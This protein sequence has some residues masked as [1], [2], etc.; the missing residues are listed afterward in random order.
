MAV[1]PADPKGIEMNDEHLLNT[2]QA[3]ELLA[4]HERTLIQDRSS[5]RL[6]IPFIRLGRAIRYQ[7]TDLRE[8]IETNRVAA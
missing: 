7:P 5:G 2:K 1:Y 3:A 4:L 6:N 8:F